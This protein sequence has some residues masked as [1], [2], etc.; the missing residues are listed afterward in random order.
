MPAGRAVPRCAVA[1]L[2]LVTAACE[3]AP[4]SPKVDAVPSAARSSLPAPP[5]RAP[6]AAP[7]QPPLPSAFAS[8][9]DRPPVFAMRAVHDGKA[10]ELAHAVAYGDVGAV[11]V[12]FGDKLLPCD[13]TTPADATTLSFSLPPGPGRGFFAGHA[14]GR[15]VFFGSPRSGGGRV[16]ASREGDAVLD[17]FA[18][19]AR[20]RG[21][22]TSA[23]ASG[24]FDL[25]LCP[26]PAIAQTLGLPAEAPVTPFSGTVAGRAFVPKAALAL[27]VPQSA[28]RPRHVGAVYFFARDDV[29][30]DLAA[31]AFRIGPAI[32]LADL[33]GGAP[34]K[35]YRG[36]QPAGA[37]WYDPG[38]E[39]GKGGWEWIGGAAGGAWVRFDALR[40][41]KDGSVRGA[42]VVQSEPGARIAG[43]L[44]GQFEARVCEVDR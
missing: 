30:C 16:L 25:P 9:D 40:L 11:H 21:R 33:G 14:I 26:S 28:E 19:G 22:L 4:P 24:S 23:A 34:D 29:P 2:A 35:G 36:P 5:S 32:E 3:R 38:L 44:A 20:V 12:V 13:G 6:L 7:V 17:L 1:V 10:M 31:E 42:A 18:V 39:Q 27:V 41:A 37:R 43:S 8:A 15:D